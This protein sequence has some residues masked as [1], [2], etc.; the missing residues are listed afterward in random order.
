VTQA[1]RNLVNLVASTGDTSQGVRDGLA[2]K[3]A[4]L[5][6]LRRRLAALRTAR[7][8]KEMEVQPDFVVRWTRQLERL[9]ESDPLRARGEIGN[10]IG[11]LV[12]ASIS[13]DRRPGVM[14]HGNPK[15]D[16]ILGVVTGGH[17][18]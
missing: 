15:V 11:T 9:M 14:L 2:A 17:F 4:E 1:V 10:I 3:E 12:A 16:G 13:H 18:E 8:F 6:T 5:V 7:N